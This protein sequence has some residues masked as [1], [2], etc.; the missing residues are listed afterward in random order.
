MIFDKINTRKPNKFEIILLFVGILA[1]AVGYF[2]VHMVIMEHGLYSYETTVSMLL[3][4]III[5]LIVLTA[6]NENSK[7]ELKIIIKQQHDEMK[8]LREDMRRK[9]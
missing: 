1:A 5:I 7:E 2:F 4:Y 8:L 6:V 3:W 9:K